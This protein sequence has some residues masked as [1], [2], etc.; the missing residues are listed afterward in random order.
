MDGAARRHELGDDAALAWARHLWRRGRGG[1]AIAIADRVARTSTSDPPQATAVALL[2]AWT[3]W[4]ELARLG[5]ELA[6]LPARYDASRELARALG[7][8]R[9]LAP[10]QPLLRAP[11]FERAATAI[12]G[13]IDAMMGRAEPGDAERMTADLLPAARG[14]TTAS[15]DPRVQRKAGR[16]RRDALC[17]LATALA[18]RGEPGAG[19]AL[20]D[21]VE[22]EIDGLA[23]V[24]AAS[25][26]AAAA[27]A[28]VALGE[29][30][31]AAELLTRAARD[32]DDYFDDDV[33][34]LGVLWF[35]DLAAGR[36]MAAHQAT[37][38]DG[39]PWRPPEPVSR[40]FTGPVTVRVFPPERAAQERWRHA[41]AFHL[42][43]G[44]LATPFA[45]DHLARALDVV[46]DAAR[47]DRAYA[48]WL[49]AELAGQLDQL[50]D[51][52]AVRLI[53]WLD[54]LR[55]LDGPGTSSGEASAIAEGAR[56]LARSG[57]GPAALAQARRV[58]NPY[59]GRRARV[60]AALAL[61]AIP[62]SV[63]DGRAVLR[64]IAADSRLDDDDGWGALARVALADLDAAPPATPRS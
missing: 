16:F 17:E 60:E 45:A 26:R 44:R 19:R 56:A 14:L 34:D 55:P 51:R 27:P 21:E 11:P 31:R 40:R 39:T 38:T 58:A 28:L 53:G 54:A 50:D 46:D 7:A 37:W 48:P 64:A 20:V 29:A 15:P 8:A 1:E 61:T 62:A 32:L 9:R 12:V 10:L 43:A 5:A 42:G 23:V 59:L 35:D 63:A 33:D 3:A 52:A 24:D 49:I 41:I 4:P 22:G 30:G 36:A 25:A 57:R 18:R 47:H 2:G 13:A 6:A